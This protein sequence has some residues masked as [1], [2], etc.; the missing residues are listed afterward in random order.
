M[1]PETIL[2]GLG[3]FFAASQGELIGHYD[4]CDVYRLRTST[5][6]LGLYD[7]RHQRLVVIDGPGLAALAH[8]LLVAASPAPEHAAQRVAAR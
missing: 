2:Q 4:Q 8:E 5:F 1:K 6:R 7:A 3:A